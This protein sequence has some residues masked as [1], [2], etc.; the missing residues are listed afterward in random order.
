M[1][2]NWIK[3]LK[4]IDGKFSQRWAP[5]LREESSLKI[6]EI[7]SITQISWHKEFKALL[8]NNSETLKFLQKFLLKSQPSTPLDLTKFSFISMS[9][10]NTFQN[11]IK[12]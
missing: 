4:L 10:L 1:K 11:K 6:L 7:Q 9:R 5:V 2:F 8:L 3:N 12:K